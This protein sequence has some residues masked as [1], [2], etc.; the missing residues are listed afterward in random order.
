MGMSRICSVLCL[1]VLATVTSAEEPEMTTEEALKTIVES[2]TNLKEIERKGNLDPAQ[3]KQIN[4][5]KAKLGQL[6]LGPEDSTG[7]AESGPAFSANN[8][9]GLLA[10]IPFGL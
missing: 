1:L 3:K 6:G 5:M 10:L 9:M 2:L 7:E 4:E 8:K